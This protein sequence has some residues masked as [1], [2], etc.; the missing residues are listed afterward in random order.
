M[1]VT[2][3]ATPGSPQEPRSLSQSECG[4]RRGQGRI[5]IT[6]LVLPQLRHL[7]PRQRT[8]GAALVGD[9]DP[10]E[11][12]LLRLSKATK[13]TGLI[14]HQAQARPAMVKTVLRDDPPG[15]V[16]GHAT[17]PTA[18][19][20]SPTRRPPIVRVWVCSGHPG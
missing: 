8:D 4:Q 9:L 2:F 17:V 10:G 12:R 14:G 16:T 11:F 6:T 13:Q 5:R 20:G 1:Q 18:E 19:V 15:K 7:D 3:Q